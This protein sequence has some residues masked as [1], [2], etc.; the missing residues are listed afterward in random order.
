MLVELSIQNIAIIDRLRVTFEPA[1]NALTGETGAGKSIIIDALGAVVGG[2]TS[3]DMLRSGEERARIEAVFD[4]TDRDDAALRA[5]LDEAGIE[6]EDGTL[7]LSRDLQSN[8]RSVARINGQTVTV[9]LLGRV[10][11][12]LV[13]IHGQSAHLS[14]LRPVTHLDFLDAYAGLMERRA[15]L[16]ALVHRVRRIRAER[17][18]LERDDRELARRTDLLRF[19]VDEIASANLEADEDVTLRA[20]RQRLV[21]ASNLQVIADTIYRTLREG[22]P[23]RGTSVVE[24]LRDVARNLGEL[25]KLDPTLAEAES[26]VDEMVYLLEDVAATIRTYRDTVE[27]NPMRLAEV[28]ERLVLIRDLERKYGGTVEEVLAFG[29]EAQRELATLEGSEERLAHLRDE[30]LDVLRQIGLRAG[31]LSQA[32][33]KAAVRLAKAVEAEIAH[34]AMGRTRFTVYQSQEE[35][36]E[37]A[38]VGGD[39]G[40]GRHLAFDARGVDRVEFL[41]APNVGEAPKPLARIASGGETARLMLA[42]KS[43]LAAADATPTLVFDEVD[44]GIGGRSGQ[45]VGETLSTLARTHQVLCITHLAQVAAFADGHFRIVK[46][47][48]RGRTI[49]DVEQLDEPERIEELAAMLD[50][51]PITPTARASARDL[52]E[53]AAARKTATDT[54]RQPAAD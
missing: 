4:V 14:L 25:R 53:R 3:P 5:L 34:L 26:E 42:L 39:D 40:Q 20:E 48:L 30:E 28:E 18:T 45:V 29:E 12:R 54:S 8:G 43:V 6:D 37:G 50:G 49:A 2:R 44:V 35:D 31:K 19:Q 36:A 17:A 10:G 16:A 41:I 11:E 32:R 52:A 15:E 51:V 27:D 24:G 22:T 9:G 13:D 38:P 33:Q 47:D 21:N 46:R 23:P 1:M 7:I